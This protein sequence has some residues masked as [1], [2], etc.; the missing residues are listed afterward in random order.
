MS[1]KQFRKDSQF[2][3]IKLFGERRPSTFTI[4]EETESISVSPEARLSWQ[5][6][7]SPVLWPSDL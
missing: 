2:E 6:E 1:S 4:P 7:I 5:S 3:I